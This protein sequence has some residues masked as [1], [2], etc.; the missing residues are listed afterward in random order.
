ME[1]KRERDTEERERR[2]QRERHTKSTE[3]LRG[4]YGDRERETLS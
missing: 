2:R 3:D 4:R 1:R